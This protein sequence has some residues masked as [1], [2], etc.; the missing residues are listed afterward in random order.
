MPESSV[1]YVDFH[2][3]SI[4]VRDYECDIEGIVNNAVYLNYLEHAR[5][6]FLKSAGTSFLELHQQGYDP[7]VVRIEI[8][9]LNVLSSGDKITV[10]TNMRMK[11]RL[12]FIFSQYIVGAADSG[13]ISRARVVGTFLRNGKPTAPPASIA[14]LLEEAGNEP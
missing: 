7:V 12:R 5:H 6:E 9:Y 10:Y 14:H 1:N 4:A 3:I 8:D 13:E 2:S 11:G